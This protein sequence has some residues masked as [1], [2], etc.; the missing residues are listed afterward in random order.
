MGGKSSDAPGRPAGLAAEGLVEGSS[1]GELAK[2]KPA[3]AMPPAKKIRT[4]RRIF[5]TPCLPSFD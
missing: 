3:S 5:R 1:V 2:E 4:T